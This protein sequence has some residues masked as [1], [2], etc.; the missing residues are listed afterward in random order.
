MDGGFGSGKVGLGDSVGLFGKEDWAGR[1]SLV[2]SQTG[3]TQLPG[4]DAA[5]WAVR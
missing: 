1:R 4:V 5:K 2:S 3:A